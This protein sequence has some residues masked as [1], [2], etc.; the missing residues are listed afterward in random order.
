MNKEIR[1]GVNT[2]F[3]VPGDVG[4]TETFLRKTLEAMAQNFPDI[5]LVL[6]TTI[7]NEKVL[8]DDLE[9]YSQV[10]FIQLKFRASFRPLRIVAEQTLLPYLVK[11]AKVDVLWS[12]GYTA[13]AW[14]PCPQVVTVPDLQ[15]KSHPEDMS[16]LER[17]VIDVLVKVSCKQ[18]DAIITISEFSR[19]EVV[20][21]KFASPPKVTSVHLG[22]DKS[23]ANAVKKEEVVESVTSLLSREKPYI[24]C[25]AH[26]YPH[27]NVHL[28][29]EAYGSIQEEIPHDLVLVGKARRGEDL[30]CDS[31][32]KVNDATR[33]HRLQGL[34]FQ[35]LKY[36]FQKADFFVLPS[37]Y[38]GFGLPVLE[39]MMAGILVVTSKKASL[40]EVGGD[41]VLY[42][43]P[44]TVENLAVSLGIASRMDPQE[45]KKIQDAART[46]AA[47]FTWEKTAGET[48]DILQDIAG[49]KIL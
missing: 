14:C 45:K 34:D 23:F 21:Y 43:D 20:R 30:V 25:V 15:Y 40:P 38:E 28:L 17:K 44:L 32:N 18:S 11:K 10:E 7:D 6:F 35:S 42:C 27:K 13:P 26:T 47:L 49:E 4:G 29:V 5:P 39:A 46:S 9:E 48:M 22:V 31:L 12:P 3:M 1:V 33:V 24:L 19:Q 36:V 8:R 16:L 41:N 37:A 2:L